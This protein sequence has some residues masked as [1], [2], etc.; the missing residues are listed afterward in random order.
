[1]TEYLLYIESSNY[2]IIDSLSNITSHKHPYGTP[3]YLKQ[4]YESKL[5]ET[6]V[7]HFNAFRKYERK[8]KGSTKRKRKVYKNKIK[9]ARKGM[10]VF[11][12]KASTKEKVA[13]FKLF[14]NDV[15][16]LNSILNDKYNRYEHMTNLLD[17]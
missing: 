15:E 1:M 16:S 11:M 3:V 10:Y 13:V 7:G 2:V 17:I 6:F 9:R 8:L 4:R 14:K 5:V 12:E